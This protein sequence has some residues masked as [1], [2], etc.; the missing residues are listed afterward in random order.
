MAT[1][2][3]LQAE[4]RVG[5]CS[6]KAYNEYLQVSV[7]KYGRKYN[8]DF[9]DDYL[10]CVNKIYKP[11]FDRHCPTCGVDEKCIFKSI[12]HDIQKM[13][14][15]KKEVVDFA[16]SIFENADCSA[17][18]VPKVVKTTRLTLKLGRTPTFV[19]VARLLYPGANLAA[20]A[21]DIKEMNG[22]SSMRDEDDEVGGWGAVA[23]ALASDFFKGRPAYDQDDEVGFVNHPS[24]GGGLHLLGGGWRGDEDDDLGRWTPWHGRSDEDD[25]V[26]ASWSYP[27]PPPGYCSRHPIMC[28]RL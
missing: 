2:C 6:A 5:K 13:S 18:I 11:F 28:R 25:E 22:R 20:I 17:A 23:K 4:A 1:F 14:Q 10:T 26:G 27:G 9:S 21:A 7:N 24:Q 3:V 8:I 15:N 16:L 12:S 19:E